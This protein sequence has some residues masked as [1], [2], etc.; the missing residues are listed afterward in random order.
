M[1]NFPK[2]HRHFRGIKNTHTENQI[3][4]TPGNILLPS[5]GFCDVHE[6]SVDIRNTFHNQNRYIC[7]ISPHVL[8][9][10]VLAVLWFFFVA[11][12]CVA[13]LGFFTYCCTNVYYL[14]IYFF[15]RFG[16]MLT[17]AIGVSVQACCS[18]KNKPQRFKPCQLVLN[19]KLLK[20]GVWGDGDK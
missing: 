7:E 13:V 5:M 9:Q 2:L 3:F 1:G 17:S 19:C 8:Y 4:F 10:Y 20:K 15:P 18:F 16:Q 12:C 11:S 6:A 14:G